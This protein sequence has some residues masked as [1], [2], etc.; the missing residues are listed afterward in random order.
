[1]RLAG[2]SVSRNDPEFRRICH[3]CIIV[4]RILSVGIGQ[5]TVNILKIDKVAVLDIVLHA[6]TFFAK[7]ILNV[8]LQ[9]PSA[10]SREV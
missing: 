9:V 1:M 8:K 2:L 6:H 7:I 10:L 5:F 4:E 3:H